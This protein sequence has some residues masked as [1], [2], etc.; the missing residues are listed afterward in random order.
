MNQS[1]ENISKNLN[2]IILIIAFAFLLFAR[3][4]KISDHRPAQSV[5]TPTIELKANM[6]AIPAVASD[7]P[8]VDWTNLNNIHK[9]NPVFK[10]T[11]ENIFNLNV[12]AQ[13]HR[14]IA[15]YLDSKP[16]ILKSFQKQLLPRYPDPDDSFLI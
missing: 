10:T 11:L 14:C 15:N 8:A 5:W 7:I 6:Q 12:T 4:E 2:R 1:T 16:F 3:S 9:I 13:L